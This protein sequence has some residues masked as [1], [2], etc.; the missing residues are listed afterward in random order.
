[1]KIKE[2][3]VIADALKFTYSLDHS[4]KQYGR[5]FSETEG[6][7]LGAK[8]GRLRIPDQL[9]WWNKLDA[10]ALNTNNI[11]LQLYS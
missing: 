8:S 7:Q 11:R 6:T 10:M 5:L 4:W 2:K 9:I 3:R 1:M